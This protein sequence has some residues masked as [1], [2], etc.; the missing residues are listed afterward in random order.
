MSDGQKQKKIK[1]MI[2]F[3]IFQKF[4][5]TLVIFV[6]YINFERVSE[7]KSHTHNLYALYQ[8]NMI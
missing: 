2:F 4:F 5:Y 7:A 3:K 6:W 1:I 8:K